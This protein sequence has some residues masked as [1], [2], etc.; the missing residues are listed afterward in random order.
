[1]INPDCVSALTCHS[2]GSANV[3]SDEMITGGDE[4]ATDYLEIS[5]F[6][7]TKNMSIINFKNYEH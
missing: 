6:S 2:S 7:H 5:Q 3:Y 1:M 4:T